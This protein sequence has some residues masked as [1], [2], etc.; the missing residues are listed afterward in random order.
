VKVSDF[1]DKTIG[2][3]GIAVGVSIDDTLSQKWYNFLIDKGYDKPTDTVCVFQPRV[4]VLDNWGWCTGSC[5]NPVT[6]ALWP[7]GGCY[8]D[9][10]INSAGKATTAKQC[11]PDVAESWKVFDNIVV[12]APGE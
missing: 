12:V 1:K 7:S 8:D 4:Q 11:F 2:D 10:L 6:N 9:D 5:K 3:T